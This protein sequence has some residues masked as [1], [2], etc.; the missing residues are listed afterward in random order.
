[1]K[2]Q[3]SIYLSFSILQSNRSQSIVQ[4][5]HFAILLQWF[6]MHSMPSKLEQ[7]IQ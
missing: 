6:P 4:K 7:Q 1:M 3:I 2:L 5:P